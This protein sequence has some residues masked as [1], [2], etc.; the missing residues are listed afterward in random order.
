[1]SRTVNRLSDRNGL[2]SISREDNSVIPLFGKTYTTAS[3]GVSNASS[4]SYILTSTAPISNGDLVEVSDATSS[5]PTFAGLD[6]K[7]RVFNVQTSGGIT[8]FSA[9]PISGF[10]FPTSSSVNVA[11]SA[12]VVPLYTYGW[13]FSNC[14]ETLQSTEQA[15]QY[16]YAFKVSPSSTDPITI[17]L[18]N[19]SLLASDNGRRFS[20]NALFKPSVTVT[21]DAQ[22]YYDNQTS[23]TAFQNVLYGGRY[24]AIRAN[25]CELPDDESI[26]SVSIVI[27]ISNHESKP[28]YFTSP[29][30]IDDQFYYDNIFVSEA[31]N[32]MPDLYWDIDSAQENPVAPFHKFIDA[33]TTIAGETQEKYLEI[34]PFEKTEIET[35]LDETLK[36]SN[37]TLI[38][39]V[40]AETEYLDWLGQF[41]G[42]K[43][44]RNLVDGNGDK[45]F[46]NIDAE[47]EFSRWQVNTGYFG[48][49]AGSRDAMISAVK[50]VLMFTDDNSDSTF[51]VAL[52]P[53]YNNDPFA[54]R[55]Q[56]LINET[57]D[58]TVSGQESQLV[59]RAVE[60]ARPLGYKVTHTA[61]SVFYFTIGDSSLG[62]I[63][64]SVPLSPPSDPSAIDPG[65]L[66]P[67][68]S[69]NPSFP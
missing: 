17:T 25:N 35:T 37:S 46:P 61:A 23:T 13:E 66:P 67:W 8:S 40:F 57:P 3:A 14:T 49:N 1:V 33:M 10:S 2:Y 12:N 20:F 5:S 54:I 52:T 29:N 11:V 34:F 63:G 24:N 48:Q 69:S 4:A 41:V 36:Y 9:S 15:T 51:S 56:T 62:I 30:L 6:G 60:G 44:K 42:A 47:N 27:E 55:I 19:V 64:G 7:K 39:P 38:N 18:S 50:Q 65:P 28:I 26:H 22:L 31:R 53:R 68:P 16:R 21:I 32:Y 43:L 45:Y 58:V 59:L